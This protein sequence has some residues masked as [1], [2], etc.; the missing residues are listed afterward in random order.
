[1]ES[2]EFN[3][4]AGAVLATG[5]LVLGLKNLGTEVFKSEAPEKP[6]FAISIAEAQ[7]S[8]G[9]AA[10]AA[11]PLPV[12]LAKAD[13]DKGM[14]SVKACTACHDLTK[15]GPNKVGPNLW[16]VVG[17][18]MGAAPGF[19]YSDGFKAMGDKTWDFDSLNAWLKAPKELIKGTK[20]AFGGIGNDQDR[21]NVLAYLDSLSDSPKPF[22]ANT[23][24]A[25]AA[26]PAATATASAAT[27]TAPAA[28]AAAPAA[29]AAAPV[30]AA[31]GE[32][33][34]ALLAKADKDR[35]QNASKACAACHD[36]TKG[37]PNK[38]GPNLWDVMGRNM[39][40]AADFSY[41]DALKAMSAKPWT[42]EELD[43]WL[44]SPKTT[45]AGT[46]MAFAGIAK[47]QDRADVIAYLASLS[48]A[49]KPFPKP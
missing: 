1:M 28:T 47:D 49:P 13:K 45:V 21:A 32:S 17:R 27:A 9:G 42:Y 12:L 29:T 22:P 30:A 33:L 24:K 2:F 20:M 5:L 10:V 16:D 25:A 43:A 6:G 7:A 15:G 39:A 46:K 34:G 36:F 19:V 3:K 37:G 44:K 48:D 38:V 26:A 31:A 35:G 23:E 11:V 14:A 18:K 4:I 40:A 8:A 41:S